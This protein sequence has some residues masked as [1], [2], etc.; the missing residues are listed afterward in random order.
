M[1]K[2]LPVKHKVQMP[3]RWIGVDFDRTLAH[4]EVWSSVLTLGQPL[5][6]MVDRVKKWISEGKKV[7]IFTARITP[8]FDPPQV[9]SAD[10]IFVIQNWCEQHIGARLEVTATKDIGMVELWDDRAVEVI[11]NVGE[12]RVPR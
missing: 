5:Y 12:P 7:K 9:T 3:E 1:R 11:P 4:Y 10:V 6:P 2:A 8:P